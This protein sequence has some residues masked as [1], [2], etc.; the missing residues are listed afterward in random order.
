MNIHKSL[1]LNKKKSIACLD[2]FGLKS[3]KGL[4]NIKKLVDEMVE[5]IIE[6][7]REEAE[8]NSDEDTIFHDVD[9]QAYK[10]KS[11]IF[12]NGNHNQLLNDFSLNKNNEENNISKSKNKNN[13]IRRKNKQITTKNN[14][15][16]SRNKI[17]FH[18]K[19]LNNIIFVFIYRKYA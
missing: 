5:T 2:I 16:Y 14:I 15:C 11:Q 18:I 7:K 1:N 4:N 17:S 10:H 9:V 12:M 6:K 8:E 13:S 3:E 19:I